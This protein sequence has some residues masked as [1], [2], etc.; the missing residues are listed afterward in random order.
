MLEPDSPKN[1]GGDNPD[2][3]GGVLVL[4]ATATVGEKRL[5]QLESQLKSQLGEERLPIW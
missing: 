5:I 3:Q 2:K 4:P 1:A